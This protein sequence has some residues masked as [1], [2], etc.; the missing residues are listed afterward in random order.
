MTPPNFSTTF[1]QKSYLEEHLEANA[2]ASQ[3]GFVIFA[4]MK[5]KVYLLLFIGLSLLAMSSCGGDDGLGD[6]KTSTTVTDQDSDQTTATIN[7][8]YVYQ[9]P[10]IFHVFYTNESE[11]RQS[12]TA[13]RLSTLLQYVNLMYQG[14]VYGTSENIHVNFV[15]AQYDEDGNKLS[16]PGVEYVKWSDTFPVDENAFMSDNKK[17]YTKYLWDPNDYINVMIY[18]FKDNDDGSVTLG[19]SHMPFTLT[20]ST[21]LEGLAKAPT[22]YISKSQLAFPYCVSINSYYVGQ[23][24]SGGYYQSNRY[25]NPTDSVITYHPADVVVTLSHELGHYLGL[26]HD[27]TEVVEDGNAVA[28]DSCGDTDYCEDTPSYNR[29]EYNEYI[30]NYLSN[31]K[32]GT[33]SAAAVVIRYG[34]DGTQFN[35]VNLMDYFYSFGYQFSAD[36][37]ARM[38]HVLYYSPLIPGPKRNGTNS[39]TRSG[40]AGTL[41]LRPVIIK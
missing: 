34:C 31:Y 9:L 25:T 40:G 38:R 8:D 29:S 23:A 22:R 11:T 36:Q 17:T 18:P 21:Q 41:N 1:Y 39:S 14:G 4:R 30:T 10:V 27:F 7:D 24:A 3:G 28:V 26:F 13:S 35:S 5:Q 37:K 33:L 19:I 2:L 32:S 6:S 16:T 12:I 20:D 15:L